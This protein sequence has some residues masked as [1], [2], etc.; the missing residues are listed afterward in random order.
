MDDLSSDLTQKD[1]QALDLL[2]DSCALRRTTVPLP[3]G[4]EVKP[5]NRTRPRIQAAVSKPVLHVCDAPQVGDLCL[6]DLDVSE[7]LSLNLILSLQAEVGLT[8][9]HRVQPGEL[10]LQLGSGLFAALKEGLK[11]RRAQQL[12]ALLVLQMLDLIPPTDHIPQGVRPTSGPKAQTY[13]DCTSEELAPDP[14]RPVPLGDP[15]LSGF[16]LPL[17][18]VSAPH[19][20]FGHPD[21]ITEAAAP[22]GQFGQ[23]VLEESSARLIW[24]VGGRV[25]AT[26]QRTA[27]PP[28]PLTSYLA[29]TT[30]RSPASLLKVFRMFSLSSIQDSNSWQLLSRRWRR[31]VS[32]RVFILIFIIYF[33]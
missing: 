9:I 3:A 13:E 24:P 8:R 26:L 14:G 20:I 1:L 23:E 28:V 21:D 2:Q 5:R 11:I 25:R 30:S 6:Q 4:Q 12:A 22:A 27:R 31:S 18:A 15:P 19:Q 29:W 10:S 7:C 33:F 32:S 16:D 17:F